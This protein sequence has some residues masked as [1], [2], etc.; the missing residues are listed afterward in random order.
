MPTLPV[1]SF[2]RKEKTE[3]QPQLTSLEAGPCS[4]LLPELVPP[5]VGLKAVY[6]DQLF[7][8]A[9]M[10]GERLGGLLDDL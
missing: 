7:E 6:L 3:H 4:G 9:H 10:Q 2:C 5:S 1:F 8:C